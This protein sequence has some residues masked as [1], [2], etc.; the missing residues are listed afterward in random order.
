CHAGLGNFS[1]A[2][3]ILDEVHDADLP[4]TPSVQVE[5]R[6]M[7]AAYVM[8]SARDDGWEA[9]AKHARLQSEY[10]D[11]GRQDADVR[12]PAR[13]LVGDGLFFIGPAKVFAR[14]GNRDA[15]LV[16][17]DE[18]ASTLGRFIGVMAFDR[19]EVADFVEVLWYTT[20]LEHIDFAEQLVR[21]QLERDFR[22]PGDDMRL[23][24]ARICALNGEVDAATGWFDA[25]R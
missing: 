22:S 10:V 23:A 3:R 20:Y 5:V 1:E 12:R 7:I 15:A 2:R 18:D 6:L 21:A 24:M 9:I 13:V 11:V 4:P 19:L 16:G 25:S 14:R 8:A 17:L